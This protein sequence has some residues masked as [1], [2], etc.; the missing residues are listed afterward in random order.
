MIS[1]ELTDFLS[2][3]ALVFL[4][5]TRDEKI[6]P[7]VGRA[8]GV[9]ISEDKQSINILVPESIAEPHL[10]NLKNNGRMA[11]TAI[12]PGTHSSYQIKGQYKEHEKATEAEHEMADK[13]KA[14]FLE[15]LTNFYGAPAAA[16]Y[17]TIVWKP[18]INIT[19][20]AEDIFNQTPGVGA[21]K[22]IN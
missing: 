22:K 12:S 21:G 5:G 13:N 18:A 10:L 19:I 4:I 17:S 11:F 8:C 14:A 20:K 1:K 9:Q 7:L 3:P 16:N 2:N 15:L 6:Q